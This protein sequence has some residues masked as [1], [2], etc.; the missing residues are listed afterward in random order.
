[1]RLGPILAPPSS[2]PRGGLQQVSRQPRRADSRRRGPGAQRRGKAEGAGLPAGPYNTGD[3]ANGE[4]KFALC[5]S[6]HTLAEGG[7]NMTGPNLYGVIGTKAGEG[8]Q[9]FKFSDPLKAS[10]SSGRLTSWIRG[11][12]SRR[13]WCPAAR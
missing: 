8:H 1:M 7:A 4:A 13:T 10:A 11:S 12:P 5:Q 9:D 2:P 6:C 3:L